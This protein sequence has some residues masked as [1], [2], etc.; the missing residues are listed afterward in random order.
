LERSAVSCNGFLPFNL[1]FRT[2]K[3]ESKPFKSFILFFD[4]CRATN[5]EKLFIVVLICVRV[6]SLFPNAHSLSKQ[7]CF[8][9]HESQS[10]CSLLLLLPV[11][12][13][14]FINNLE[15]RR[16]LY[17]FMSTID[18]VPPCLSN[19]LQLSSHEHSARKLTTRY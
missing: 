9:L 12:L 1:T 16:L 6:F 19:G 14:A 11:D 15:Q 7:I 17:T 18:R 8:I 5:C 4:L 3:R 2:Q 10:F 13:C